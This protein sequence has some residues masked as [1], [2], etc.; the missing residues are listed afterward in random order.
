[1]N[2]FIFLNNQKVCMVPHGA[3]HKIEYFRALLYMG[4]QA[5]SRYILKKI[6]V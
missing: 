2:A 1:M 5:E 4:L 6:K 3:S